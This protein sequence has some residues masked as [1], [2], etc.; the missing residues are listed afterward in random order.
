MR[1]ARTLLL[2]FA[3]WLL[4]M[5]AGA[6]E[7]LL[8]L[9]PSGVTN[10]EV[11]TLASDKHSSTFVIFIRD[12]VPNHIHQHHSESIYVLEGQ[13]LMRLG[14]KTVAIGPGDFLHVPEGRV[15]GVQVTSETPLKVLS[16]QAPEFTGADRV[17]VKD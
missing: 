5:A 6:K 7:N 9:E 16:I 10:I 13:G 17:L 14:D 12:A 1:S 8:G 2:A 4:A 11:I 3:A 15:H